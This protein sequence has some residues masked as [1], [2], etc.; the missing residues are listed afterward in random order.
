MASVRSF[1]ALILVLFLEISWVSAVLAF[2][3]T[4]VML[5]G[6]SAKLNFS[7]GEKARV[8]PR[9]N[10]SFG[11]LLELP[12]ENLFLKYY[13]LPPWKNSIRRKKKKNKIKKKWAKVPPTLAEG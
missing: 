9:A 1:K 11:V 3:R 2:C 6:R 7:L 10:L 5:A 8:Y 13:S 12:L 4:R